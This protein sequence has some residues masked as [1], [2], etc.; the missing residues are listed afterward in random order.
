MIAIRGATTVESDKAELIK[1]ASVELINQILS[2]NELVQSQVIL[3]TATST[4]DIKSYYPVRAVR[5]AGY[6]F[7]LFSAAEPEIEGGLARCIRFLVLVEKNLHS[8]KPKHIYLNRAKNLRRDISIVNIAIDG[9]AGSGKSTV[10][11][12]VAEKLKMDYV[13]T[14]AMYRACALFMSIENVDIK[15]E[16]AVAAA[17]AYVNVTLDYEGGVQHTFLNG[18]DVTDL[19]RTPEITIASSKI[20]KY[21]FVRHKLVAAQ[22]EIAQKN[23]CVLDGRDIGSFVLPNADFKFF[24]TADSR[25][26]AKRRL[27]EL[28]A[29]GYDADLETVLEEIKK[30]DFNDLNRE[31]APLVKTEDAILIDTSDITAIQ[32]AELIVKI[33]GE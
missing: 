27:G 20:S 7:P 19:I 31:T 30:R 9:P 16:K 25:I 28:I 18:K 8:F 5:E 12:L 24:L 4:A 26:R 10:A 17:L 22:R 6:N 3:L 11:K 33:V 15:D 23:S 1:A 32:A 2:E 21:K 14:G 29:N 13:D